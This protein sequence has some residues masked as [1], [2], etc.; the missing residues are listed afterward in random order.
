MEFLRRRIGLILQTLV[1][2]LIIAWLMKIVDWRLVWSHVRTMETAWIVTGILCFA[3]VLFIISWRW[4][5]LLAA[6]RLANSGDPISVIAPSLGYES[7][8]AFST[9]FKRVM[10]CPPGRYGRGER[11]GAMAMREAA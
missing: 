10:A 5:M 7:E 11:S 4:R 2:A 1:S 8:S 3:P 6:E 9:A